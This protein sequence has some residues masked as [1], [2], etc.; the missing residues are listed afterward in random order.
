M[1]SER[2]RSTFQLRWPRFLACVVLATAAPQFCAARFGNRAAPT[3]WL[4]RAERQALTG[5][6]LRA[7]RL[8]GG[9]RKPVEP[10]PPE[11]PKS[12][13]ER[14]LLPVGLLF[15]LSVGLVSLTPAP[16]L[17]D[18]IGPERATALLAYVAA[19]SAMVEIAAAP[20]MGALSDTIG[21]KPVLLGMLALVVCVLCLTAGVPSVA[22]I[23]LSKFACSLV[24]G[25]FFMTTSA[26]L[27]DA[28][29]DWPALLAS[30]TGLLTAAIFGGSSVGVIV[31]S[32]LPGGVRGSYVASA[33]AACCALALGLIQVNETMPEE[34]RVPFKMRSLSPL[35]G[36]RLLRMGSRAR[37]LTLLFGLL[38]QPLFMGDVLQVYMIDQWQLAKSDM[39]DLVSLR[40]IAGMI[41]NTLSG[42]LIGIAGVRVFAWSAIASELLYWLGFSSSH[43]AALVCAAVGWL[44]PARALSANT[45]LSAEGARMGIPQGLLAGYRGNFVAILKVAGPLV[46]GKLYVLGK[47]R[48]LP[49]L[50]FLLNSCCLLLAFIIS[51]FALRPPP[52]T[53]SSRPED[54]AI[55]E[56]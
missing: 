5:A 10:P 54:A 34:Q 22:L 51:G 36:F 46:H 28:Y 48:G 13:P 20:I 27:A 53:G 39:R 55:H 4:V 24:V 44:G 16:A 21:R 40:Q 38:L 6:E 11:P 43:G 41:S 17:M 31:A 3:L 45:L 56:R 1:P 25:L 37:H 47:N 29:R 49:Q 33:G 14:S 19:V 26:V 15:S 52:P 42:R 7:L 23:A 8:R 32:K 2:W 9:R 18:R 35:S 50:P 30:A 12:R